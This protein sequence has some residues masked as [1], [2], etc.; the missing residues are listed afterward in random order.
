[1]EW[2]SIVVAVV[3]GLVASASGADETGRVPERLKTPVSVDRPD[4][5]L[6][7]EAVLLYSN[8]ARRAHGRAPLRADI[9]LSRAAAGHAVNMARLQTHSHELP[10]RGQ[11]NLSQRLHRQSTEFRM[12]AE[13]IA[14]G[15]VFRLLGR[16]ISMKST[17]CHFVYGDTNE[18]VP[19]H[20]YASLANEVVARWMK[21]PKHR[22]SLLSSTFRRLGA[23][24]G[25]DPEGAACGDLY[26]VQDFAD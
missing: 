21:S 13:N 19:I 17:G 8:I 6:F 18:P 2:R 16:P 14:Q 24:I 12:A 1:M 22:A 10:L 3:L 25:G 23:G 7:N 26:L 9:G 15:K 4:Q 5:A 11:R 20:T